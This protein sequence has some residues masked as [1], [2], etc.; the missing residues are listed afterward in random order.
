MADFKATDLSLST[1]LPSDDYPN[2][3]IFNSRSGSKKIKRNNQQNE[4]A[5]IILSTSDSPLS[6]FC[7]RQSILLR[8]GNPLP[9]WTRG[10]KAP[11]PSV[12]F[13][14]SST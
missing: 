7:F 2:L 1:S 9:V 11:V 6:T 4:I 8:T 14:R 3:V 12:S 10:L 5:A 13:R